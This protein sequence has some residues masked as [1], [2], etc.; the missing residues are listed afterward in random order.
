ML[1]ADEI[2]ALVKTLSVLHMELLKRGCD[3]CFMQMHKEAKMATA[4]A[5]NNNE[6]TTNVNPARVDMKVEVVIIP[7][8]DVAEAK[9]AR[10]S[11]VLMSTP[12]R[13]SPTYLDV[14]GSAVQNLPIP[15]T[16]HSPPSMIRTATGG[17]CRRLRHD[18]P[19]VGSAILTLRR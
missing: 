3:F 15:V 14:S 13:T 9:S 1:A 6:P 2:A 7:V 16:I 5:I 19:G 11:T 10:C 18:C 17:C 12:A 8:S 4:S